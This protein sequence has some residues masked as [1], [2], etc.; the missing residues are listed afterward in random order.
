[1]KLFTL[2]LIFLAVAIFVPYAS[3]QQTPTL[4]YI[5]G[6][7]GNFNNPSDFST[8]LFSITNF[9]SSGT[10]RVPNSSDI[11]SIDADEYLDGTTGT[12]TIG[13]SAPANV[14]TGLEV[15]NIYG[16]FLGTNVVNLDVSGTLTILGG[17][18][19]SSGQFFT[20]D[21]DSTLNVI[22]GAVHFQDGIAQVGD[23]FGTGTLNLQSASLDYD[24]QTTA[25]NTQLEVGV[26][27]GAVGNVTES[28]STVTTGNTLFIGISGG[29]GNYVLQNGSTLQTGTMITTPFQPGAPDYFI[30][31][32]I[33]TGNGEGS[34][35]SL[36]ILDTST[37]SV[38]SAGTTGFLELGAVA[39]TIGGTLPNETPAGSGTITQNGAG[40]HFNLTNSTFDIG[41][42]GAPAVL[43]PPA[44]PAG[45][46]GTGVYNLVNG[47]FTATGSSIYLGL[48]GGIGKI[49]QSGGTMIVTGGSTVDIGAGGTGTYNLSGASSSASFAN[50]FSVGTDDGSTG[51]VNQTGGSL[52]SAGAV[53]IGGS[54]GAG[55]GVGSYTISGSATA[56][57]GSTL[58]IGANGALR[59]D[60]GTLSVGSTSLTGSGVISF[61]GG[62][63]KFTNGTGT[64]TYSFVSNVNTHTINLT[65]GTSTIDVSSTSI[66]TFNFANPF[67][68]SGGINLVGDGSTIFNFASQPPTSGLTSTYNGPTG[69]S[70]GSLNVNIGDIQDSGALII[71]NGGNLNVAL[72]TTTPITYDGAISGNGNLNVNFGAP[73]EMLTLGSRSNSASTVNIALGGDSATATLVLYTGSFGS[74]S[75][76]G[77]TVNIGDNTGQAFGTVTLFGNASYTG[78]TTVYPNY[79]LNVLQGITGNGGVVVSSGAFLN[80]TGNIAGDLTNAGVTNAGSITGNVLNSGSLNT[81]IIGG[82]L[83]NIGGTVYAL[84]AGITTNTGTLGLAQS[85]AMGTTF[86]INGD[87]S[88]TSSTARLLIRSDGILVAPVADAFS[89]SGTATVDSA[90]T[91]H[92]LGAGN[93]K[94]PIPIVIGATGLTPGALP[95]V[96]TNSPLLFSAQLSIGGVGDDSIELTT[97]QIPTATF[98]QTPNQKAV[99][100]S[101]DEV[102]A[103]PAILPTPQQFTTFFNLLAT[104]NQLSTGAQVASALESLTP[105]SLQYARNIAF[106][107]STFMA[108]R[109]NGVCADLRGGYEGLDSSEVSVISPGF[110]SSLGRSLGSLLAYDD[111]AFHSSAPNGV[112]YYPGGESGTPSSPSPVPTWDSSNQVISDSPNPYLAAV[113]PGSKET[114]RLSEFIGGDVVLADLNQSQS[115]SNA[116]SSKASYTAGDATAGVSFRMTSHLAAGV[117]FDYNH[118]DA[119]TD[120]SGSK[121][122][123]DSYSP[124]L[125]ATYYDHSFYVNGLFSF[126]WNNYSNTRQIPFASET[127]T[128]HPDGQQYVG[129]LDVG[130]DFHPE[131]GWIVGPTLGLTYTH[132]DIDSFS[133]TGA[134]ETDLT[135]QSQ[136]ADS[137]RSRLGGHL[138]YQTNTGD[139]LLQPNITAMWQHE[140]LDSSSGITS[141]FNNFNTSPFTIET[142]APSRDSALIGC[143]LTA[144][145]SNSMALYLNYLADVGASDYFAQSVIGGFKARF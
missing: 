56:A 65:T 81:G 122:K 50:G 100:A 145:L 93:I 16:G 92:V 43:G 134:P 80:V 97:T 96:N 91:I 82:D 9:G 136:S 118:T 112:N 137:L 39:S 31:L 124:G 98:A 61:G 107:K 89:A 101:I 27:T 85:S 21:E 77:S 13:V 8:S 29:S 114:P 15:S 7:T 138:I 71:G 132:L 4:Y 63:L 142:A 126:G 23:D 110:D 76:A 69:I 143:G 128:S 104:F 34:Y 125:F 33:N 67:N 37:F 131:K 70:G 116:P 90:S 113:K 57:F 105:E 46:G 58:S 52:S 6:T 35:G 32:G 84:G 127:A 40:S 28:A 36:T 120:S 88:S 119:S 103:N 121:T 30:G 72:G 68:G 139:V 62:T 115:N 111:P 75:G 133:E 87:F 12:L 144:T 73:N 55:A 54:G 26:G 106:D 44:Y 5:G 64:Y 14:V 129:D 108:Q 53:S 74:I 123:V 48:D 45:A 117:L 130:Y 2:G 49:N 22:G 99:A 109:M 135:V 42:P 11:V 38:G 3:A 102:T 24:F 86:N 66:G 18:V 94:T 60:G 140:Y 95:H 19:S 17:P 25:D 51:T 79:T 83:T 10:N 141:S 41:G 47:T 1:M 20:V 59:L 78:L